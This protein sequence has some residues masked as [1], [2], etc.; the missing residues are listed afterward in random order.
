MA[1]ELDESGISVSHPPAPNYSSGIML[2]RQTKIPSGNASIAKNYCE[3][4]QLRRQ[5][6]LYT[7]R[8]SLKGKT[9]ADLG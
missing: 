7:E 2:A 5:R 9:N 4:R 3:V 1:F 8:K 6:K